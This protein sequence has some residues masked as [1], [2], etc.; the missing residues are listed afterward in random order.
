MNGWTSQRGTKIRGTLDELKANAVLLDQLIGW[1]TGAEANLAAQSHEQ[2]PDNL[3]IIEQL[4]NDH[5]VALLWMLFEITR[6]FWLQSQKM[7]FNTFC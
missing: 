7:T 4:L 3:P 5:Q 1:L 2:L 6:F